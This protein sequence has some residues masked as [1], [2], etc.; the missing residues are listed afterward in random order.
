MQI[1]SSGAVVVMVAFASTACAEDD[2]NLQFAIR[3]G[4]ATH[5]AGAADNMGI[6]EVVTVSIEG[7]YR[8][9]SRYV[10]GGYFQYGAGQV[11]RCS[12]LFT[13]CSGRVLKFGGEFLV[14]LLDHRWVAPWFGLGVGICRPSDHRKNTSIDGERWRDPERRRHHLAVTFLRRYSA[15]RC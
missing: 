2:K 5:V 1:I 14:Y 11:P 6:G 7:G 8:L 12:P 15:G 10:L 13:S 4:L 9:S 3:G